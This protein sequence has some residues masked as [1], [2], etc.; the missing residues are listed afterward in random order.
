MPA[1]GIGCPIV[2][3]SSANKLFFGTSASPSKKVLAA[4]FQ[5]HSLEPNILTI[6]WKKMDAMII[7]P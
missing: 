3:L 6:L 2:V 4:T 1:G 7:D 5:V